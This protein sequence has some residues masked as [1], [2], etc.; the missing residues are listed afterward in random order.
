MMSAIYSRLDYRMTCTSRGVVP[1][2]V[3]KKL[4]LECMLMSDKLL[5]NLCC[6]KTVQKSNLAS[7]VQRSVTIESTGFS[8]NPVIG[9]IVTLYKLN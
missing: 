4:D 2:K 7:S 9:L 1:T 6:T 5:L 8:I 3:T